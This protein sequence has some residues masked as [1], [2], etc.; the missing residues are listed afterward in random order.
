MKILEG[1]IELREDTRV[2]EQAKPAVKIEEHTEQATALS[3][4]QKK[5]RV[6]TDDLVPRIR[7][8]PEGEAMFAKEIALLTEVARVMKDARSIL[9]QPNTG[10]EAMAAETE[11]IEL[12]LQSKRINPNGGGG[13]GSSPGGGGG[14][15]T[16]DSAIAL[17]GKG[18]NEKE[19]RVQKDVHH[20]TGDSMPTLPE[21]FRA[22]LDEYFNRIVDPNS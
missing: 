19:V 18:T 17:L 14:G 11:A 12:L 21:E 2:A 9:A 15:D 22:G 8:L 13:G 6:R 20:T 10:S 16:V 3:G 7:S 4:R 5:L 1:E